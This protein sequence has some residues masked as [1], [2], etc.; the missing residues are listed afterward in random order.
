MSAGA[1]AGAGREAAEEL[2]AADPL[3][4][5]RDAF[6]FADPDV[7]YLDGNSLGRLP[8]AT[9]GF[10]GQL[11]TDGWGSGLVESWET[12]ITW[13]RRLGDRLAHHTLGAAPGE[14]V[15]SDSTSV[16]LYKLAV[17]ALDA[18]P[19]RRTVLADIDD[20]PTNRY[21][22]QGL[23]E[24]RQLRLETLPSD[25]DEGLD[26][27]VLRRA[28]D[29]DVALVVLSLVS[30]RSG[31]LMD[32]A[33]VNDAAVRAGA[34]VLWDLSHA[35]GV[36]PLR[37][38]A[39]GAELA[40]GSTY[41]YLNGGPGS[42]AFLYVRKELQQQLRQPVWGW[43]GQRDQ[44]RMA[45]AYEPVDGIDRFLVGTPPLLSLAAIEPALDVAGRVP[46]T[47]LREKS[48]Q[49]GAYAVELA[50]VW[51]APLGFRLASPREPARRG[52]HIALAH[53]DAARI[54]SGLRAQER[55][56]CDFRAPDRLRIG[57]APLYTRFTDVWD[58]LDRLRSFVGG[59]HHE[60]LPAAVS[61]V[62]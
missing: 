13:A 35:A 27:D 18:A 38:G 59:R 1:G 32:M 8:S 62:T 33:A 51:L 26:L 46:V 29:Q 43:Y 60:Q 50:E 23:A 52:A 53:P 58:G 54:C 12:W 20:F 24:Q 45:P 34:R 48:V 37:L 14:V 55:V 22:L 61:R 9:A 44:F 5:F 16:N 7:I 21:I 47:R 31:A 3:R 25:P 2:D 39:D 40:V 42:P 10:L 6:V 49:L 28:L 11:V 15:L 19:G 17:A 57:L 41:K 30:Y 36:V 4:E 56:I